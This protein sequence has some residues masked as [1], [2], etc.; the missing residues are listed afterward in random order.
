MNEYA[1]T[2]TERETAKLLPVEIDT[3]AI[4]AN[5]VAGHT[6]ATLISAGTELN[7]GYLGNNFPRQSGYAAAFKVEKVGENVA[8][9]SPGDLAF[10][11]GNHA[12]YQRK[13][14]SQVIRL[15]DNLTPEIAV[16]ARMMGVSMT[17]LTT[18]SARPP[19]KY[20][21]LDSASLAISQPKTFKPVATKSMPVTRLHRG[22]KLPQKRGST[23]YWMLYHWK[24]P[25]S[26][27]NFTS[28]L[29]ARG[30]NRP[31]STQQAP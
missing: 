20:S 19:A 29:N 18:T 4:G 6:L 28:P 23:M 22:G 15:P 10:C 7:S 17:T 16:F 13:P 1:V 26:R 9:I 3:D 12:S 21:S 25:N 2:F 30:T 31:C 14:A 24:I 5:E 11:P 27:A 8:D